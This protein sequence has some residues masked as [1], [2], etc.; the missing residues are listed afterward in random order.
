MF[1]PTAVRHT[2][3]GEHLRTRYARP[4]LE[5]CPDRLPAELESTADCPD[6]VTIGRETIELA[7]L[8]AIQHLPPKQRATLLLRDVYDWPSSRFTDELVI[9]QRNMAAITAADDEVISPPTAAYIRS[10]DSGSFSAFAVSVLRVA[11]GLVAEVST[12][13]TAL[14][15]HFELPAEIDSAA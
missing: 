14:F 6:T 9:L 5:P 13:G 3:Y 8:A 11:D 1:S 15:P 2:Q 10:S 4:R 7:F 12:F